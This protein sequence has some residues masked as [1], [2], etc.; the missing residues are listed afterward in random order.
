MLNIFFYFVG[1]DKWPTQASAIQQQVAA[2]A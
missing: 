1:F 2:I